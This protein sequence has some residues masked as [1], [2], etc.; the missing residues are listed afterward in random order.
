MLL[1]AAAAVA[2]GAG[3][4]VSD[5]M[6]ARWTVDFV[7]AFLIGIALQYAAIVPMRRLSRGRGLLEA[8]KADTLSITAGQLG[9]YGLMALVQLVLAPAWFGGRLPVASVQF[10]AAMQLAMLVGFATSAPANAWLLR[11]G[12]KEPM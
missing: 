3:W 7:L 12:I 10:W 6:Y 2:A 1:V 4:L 8:V 9:M 5:E 11:R